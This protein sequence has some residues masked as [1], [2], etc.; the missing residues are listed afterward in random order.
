MKKQVDG[1]KKQLMVVYIKIYLVG[2]LQDKVRLLQNCNNY[3]FSVL[4][5]G[6]SHP[7]FD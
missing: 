7:N 6:V 4:H 1:K 5:L 2:D 3:L